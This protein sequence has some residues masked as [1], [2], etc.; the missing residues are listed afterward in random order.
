MEVRA[1]HLPC[2]FQLVDH[3]LDVQAKE[4]VRGE[5]SNQE[6]A[7]LL[8]LQGGQAQ[9][10]VPV[11]DLSGAHGAATVDGDGLGHPDESGRRHLDLID[12]HC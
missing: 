11:S 1:Q 12:F 9:P 8:H 2:C 3:S 10:E 5:R 6:E 7:L 4:L